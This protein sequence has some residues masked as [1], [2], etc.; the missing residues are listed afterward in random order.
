[1]GRKN[2]CVLIVAIGNHV[3]GRGGIDGYDFLD[4]RRDDGLDGTEFGHWIWRFE[5]DIDSEK[6]LAVNLLVDG[7]MGKKETDAIDG[8]G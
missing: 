3:D 6:G 1:M 8:N 5:F 4:W 7:V 2:V